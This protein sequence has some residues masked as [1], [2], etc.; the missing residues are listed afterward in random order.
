MRDV[1]FRPAPD[2]DEPERR[3]L[4]E[5]CHRIAGAVFE[6][7]AEEGYDDVES[8]AMDV[9]FELAEAIDD[10]DQLCLCLLESVAAELDEHL[11]PTSQS[12]ILAGAATRLQP[13]DEMRDAIVGTLSTLDVHGMIESYARSPWSVAPD[14]GT[15]SAVVRV[16]G[17]VLSSYDGRLPVLPITVEL[18]RHRPTHPPRSVEVATVDDGLRFTFSMADTTDRGGLVRAPIDGEV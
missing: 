3:T 17:Y 18:A 5:F 6:T 8:A 15:R 7:L 11:R 16:D 2:S 12:E 9:Y 1:L 10:P 13:V 14:G 4:I